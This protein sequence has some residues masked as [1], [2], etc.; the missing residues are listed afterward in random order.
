MVLIYISGIDGCGKTTQ[1][2]LLIDSLIKEGY[3]AK[4][5]WLRWEP[6]FQ[7]LYRFPKLL[8]KKKG[9]T[10]RQH[11]IDIE[12]SEHMQ[13]ADFKQKLLSCIVFRRLWWLHASIEY[14]FQMQKRLEHSYAEV[15]VVDRYLDDFIIDQAINFGLPPDAYSKEML[16]STFIKKFKKPDYKIFI[17]LPAEIGYK[18]KSDGTSLDYL[19]EREYYYKN[20]SHAEDTANLD[21]KKEISI[22]ARE[23]ADWVIDKLN[24]REK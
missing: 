20:I 19:R 11:I 22:L 24:T 21:G 4:Y 9:I 16:S 5:K 12:N 2:K 10:T 7:K 17:H 3:D 13:W 1:A 6:F 18:R 8:F 23:I 15:L 14:Y